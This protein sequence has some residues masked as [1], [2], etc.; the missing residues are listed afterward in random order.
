MSSPSYES[1]SNS[2]S[3][4][5]DSSSLTKQLLEEELMEES[6]CVEMSHNMIQTIAIH[7][8]IIL[9]TT[10]NNLNHPHGGSMPGRRFIHRDRKKHY[11]LIVN[12]YFR[13]GKNELSSLQ[14]MIAAIR[15]LAYG[16]H[17][18]LLDEYVQIGENTAIE[19]L[20]HFCDAVIG[21]F[22]E[23]YLRKPNKDDIARLLK[24][25]EGRG[26]AE[27]VASQNLW[28]WHASFGMAGTNKDIN[29][30]DSSLLF[31]DLI[32]DIAHPC[33]FVVQGHEYDMG[34]YLL[35]GIYPHYAT[36][37]QIISQPSSIKEKLYSKRQEAVRKDVEQAFEVLQS[38]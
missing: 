32:N 33:N 35:D 22:E 27:I 16:C 4:S 31:D 29:V 3:S 24:E 25:G 23:Q 21:L 11:D 14:K 37:I 13:V 28:I 34:Y 5:N 8:P 17:A 18:D 2:S 1:D 26:F 12:D 10:M 9:S 19:S 7:V 38:R 30:L 6:S 20:K 36:L 15:M